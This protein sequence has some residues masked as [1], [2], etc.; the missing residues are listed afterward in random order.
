MS[1]ILSK[2]NFFPASGPYSAEFTE[3]VCP[4]LMNFRAGVAP[5]CNSILLK[6][7]TRITTITFP[8]YR[9]ISQRLFYLLV[10]T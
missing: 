10:L 9:K 6:G 5:F 2:L 8:A 1:K 3:Q 4:S 7:R